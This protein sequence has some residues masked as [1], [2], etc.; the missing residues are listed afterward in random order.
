MGD[1]NVTSGHLTEGA[2][3]FTLSTGAT[4]RCGEPAVG[5]PDR[6]TIRTVEKVSLQ[7]TKLLFSPIWVADVSFHRVETAHRHQTFRDHAWRNDNE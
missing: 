5:M 2:L 3:F 6:V 7:D 1:Y 4:F